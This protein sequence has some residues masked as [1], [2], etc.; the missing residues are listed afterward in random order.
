MPVDRWKLLAW[1]AEREENEPGLP[2]IRGVDLIQR[3]SDL[4]GDD[5]RPWDAVVKAAAYLKRAGF[6]E[7]R[8]DPFPNGPPEPPVEFFEQMTFQ[9][10]REIGVTALGH[11][12]LAQQAAAKS[13]TQVNIVHSTVGQLALGNIENIDITV[14]LD[15]V[16]RSLEQLEAPEAEKEEARTAIQ[17]MRQAG[18]TV[19]TSAAG[20]LLAEA[21]RRALGM[22]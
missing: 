4:A 7:W 22:P 14:L 10:V 11:T 1:M 9:Q 3:A 12:K 21:L 15:G 8:F 6:V 16:E 19:A 13:G 2:T 20:S 5:G 18:S 17:R